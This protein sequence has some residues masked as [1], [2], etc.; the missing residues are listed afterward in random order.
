MEVLE[1]IQAWHK[2]QVE[3][4]RDPALGVRIETLRERPGWSV[5]IDLSGTPLS[6]LKLAPYREGATDR[7]WLAYRIKEDRFEGIGDP[8]KLPAPPFAFLYLADRTPARRA[9]AYTA[10]VRVQGALLG[11]CAGFYLRHRLRELAE[12]FGHLLAV[13]AARGSEGPRFPVRVVESEYPVGPGGLRPE[14][15]VQARVEAAA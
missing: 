11:P 15:S 2:A 1:R 10:L 6:G 12:R 7:D 9:G 5:Q 8:T 4:G 3:R 13:P 14:I